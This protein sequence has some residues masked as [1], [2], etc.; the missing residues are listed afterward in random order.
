MSKEEISSNIDFVY[1]LYLDVSMLTSFVAALEDG[2]AYGSDVTRREESRKGSAKEGQAGVGV[3][4]LSTLFNLDLRGKITSA[5][6]LNSGEEVTMVRRHTEASLF[7]KLRQTLKEKG[8]VTQID[9]VGDLESLDCK[10]FNT[11]VEVSGQIYRSPLSETLEALFRIMSM[12]GIEIPAIGQDKQAKQSGKVQQNRRNKQQSQQNTA[13]EDPFSLD[14]ESILGLQIAQRIKQDLEESKTLDVILYPEDDKNFT[15]VLS[16]LLDAL[17]V[18][19]LDNL[20]SGRFTVLGKVTRRIQGDEQINL[21]QRSVLR[22]F[23]NDD[24][25]SVFEKLGEDADLDLPDN[26]SSINS[27]ALQLMPLAIYA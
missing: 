2:V 11:L 20:L 1:P 19:A 12:L 9:T 7:M 21:Y 13:S 8:Y 24:F 15:V 3:P 4:I 22:Y 27:P 10:G 23:M 16:L 26:P 18:G 25:F 17:S 5:N 6:D 14:E